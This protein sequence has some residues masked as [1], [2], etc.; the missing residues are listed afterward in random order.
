[1]IH[2]V[3]L[4]SCLLLISVGLL[5]SSCTI[6]KHDET[7]KAKAAN[8]I[9]IYFG[10]T[11]FDAKLYVQEIWDDQVV[12]Y[13]QTKAVAFDVLMPLLSSDASSACKQYGYRVGEEGTFFNFAVQGR[14]RVVGIN[15]ESRNG[16]LYV[17]AQPYGGEQEYVLQIGPVFKGT[18]IRDIL[19]FIS[20]NDFENQVEFARL[21]NELNFKVR[22]EILAGLS[23]DQL[24]DTEVDVVAVFSYDPKNLVHVMTPVGFSPVS[25]DDGVSNE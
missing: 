9:E 5:F 23:Y 19:D 13:I 11:G 15:Q 16:L 14:V 21:A 3:S 10:N 22:D 18:S 20:L 17:D 7:D 25:D 24:M 2:K 4:F 6:K 12:P 1:M 8:E